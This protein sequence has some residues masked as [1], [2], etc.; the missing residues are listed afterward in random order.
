VIVRI[1]SEGQ[2]RLQSVHLD[3]LNILDN[4]LVNIIADCD[5]ESFRALFDDMLDYVRQNGE[6]LPPDT[7]EESDTI[8][9]PPDITLDEARS[10]FAG[11]GLVPG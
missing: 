3:A 2:Y 10:L 5:E 7:L 4:E 8:L 9:P 1:S 6:L 11:E